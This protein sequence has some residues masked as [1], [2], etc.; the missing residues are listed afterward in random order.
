MIALVDLA[1]HDEVVEL[2]V[3]LH[4]LVVGGHDDGHVV[5]ASAGAALFADVPFDDFFINI[6]G[7][8]VLGVVA[9]GHD[10]GDDRNNRSQSFNSFSVGTHRQF[11]NFLCECVYYNGKKP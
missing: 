6:F 8:C 2:G 9:L 11:L 1:V 3:L 10:V 5:Q 4:G 7:D